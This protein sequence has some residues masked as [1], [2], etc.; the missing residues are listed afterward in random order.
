LAT[1]CRDELTTPA[2]AYRTV[3]ERMESDDDGDGYG[4]PDTTTAKARPCTP[5]PSKNPKV[6][7]RSVRLEPRRMKL[8]SSSSDDDVNRTE[9][10]R[11]PQRKEDARIAGKAS[12]RLWY[13]YRIPTVTI[14]F[15]RRY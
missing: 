11:A 7:R 14:I 9:R 13:H 2:T 1:S 5:H 10:S 8:D 3:T 15:S 6:I 4:E 12:R